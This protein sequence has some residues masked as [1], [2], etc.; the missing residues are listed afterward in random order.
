[1]VA[2]AYAAESLTYRTAGMIEARKAAGPGAIDDRASALAAFEEYAAEASVAKVAG[3]EMLQ[4]VLDENVQIHGGNGFVRDYPAERHYRDARVNR[5][6]EGTN[7]IN[8]L[9]VPTLLARRAA[10]G[11][12]QIP[13]RA[14][15]LQAE[16]PTA[17]STDLLAADDPTLAHTHAAVRSAKQATRFVFGLALDTYGERLQGEQQVLLHVA[18]MLTDVYAAESATLRASAAAADPSAALHRSAARV[19]VNDATMRLYACARQALPAMLRGSAL[20]TALSEVDRL[21]KTTPID[22]AAL[23]RALADETVAKGA[24]PFQT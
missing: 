5:I 11:E 17:T 22:T 16:A 15:A 8:R 23:R 20:E 12:L 6:F 2:R 7:E 18:D 1:M 19:F 10:K 3:S 4:F 14:Q 21:L 9:L 24:Y 13:A